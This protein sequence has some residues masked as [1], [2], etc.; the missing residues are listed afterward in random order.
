MLLPEHYTISHK[1]SPLMSYC[2]REYKNDWETVYYELHNSSK[3]RFLEK[4]IN[5]FS[6][7][8]EKTSSEVIGE[9]SQS[10]A[11]SLD[12]LPSS[13]SEKTPK[14]SDHLPEGDKVAA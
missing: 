9:A 4:I 10:S 3:N 7:L 14:E 5:I 1:N 11:Y 2:K 13:E 6:S 8:F 12:S